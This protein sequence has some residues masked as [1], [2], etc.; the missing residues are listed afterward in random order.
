VCSLL[1][2][3]N[4][5]VD[6]GGSRTDSGSGAGAF[7]TSSSATTDDL[8]REL[9]NLQK[10][11]SGGKQI[12]DRENLL[13]RKTCGYDTFLSPHFLAV[14]TELSAIVSPNVYT[15]RLWLASL[16]TL[17]LEM[18]ARSNKLTE[19]RA[20]GEY[21]NI[22]NTISNHLS[23]I[24]RISVLAAPE[25][26]RNLIPLAGQVGLELRNILVRSGT[27]QSN[28]ATVSAAYTRLGGF[29]MGIGLALKGVT[30]IDEQ[31]KV[32]LMANSIVA[33]AYFEDFILPQVK[34]TELYQDNQSIRTAI[35]EYETSSQGLASQSFESVQMDLIMDKLTIDGSAFLIALA[36][37]PFLA[38]KGAAI[39]S[40][41]GIPGAVGGAVLFVAAGIVIGV[42]AD[43]LKEGAEFI[44]YNDISA[45]LFTLA[46]V[47]DSFVL[48]KDILLRSF[49]LSLAIDLLKT[50]VLGKGII[51][52]LAYIV[53][54]KNEEKRWSEFIAKSYDPVSDGV[55]LS[56]GIAI[57][58]LAQL[59]NLSVNCSETSLSALNYYIFLIDASGSMN[60]N[61]KIGQVK[62]AVPQIINDLPQ[63]ENAYAMVAYSSRYGCRREQIPVLIP[64]TN[65]A[66]SVEAAIDALSASGGTPM[67]AGIEKA[68]QYASQVIPEDASGMIILLADGQQN[69]PHGVS[70]PPLD[71]IIVE[72]MNIRKIRLSTIAYGTSDQQAQRTLV[73]LANEGHGIYVQ[74]TDPSLVKGKFRELILSQTMPE[75]K[76]SSASVFAGV[77]LLLLLLALL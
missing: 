65:D 74:A 67:R 14:N 29:I 44:L 8:E 66:E 15:R 6:Q 22:I 72:R 16:W 4:N 61:N 53:P 58:S 21:S 64:F 70:I 50:R 10:F 68:Y 76:L 36:A 56:L 49:S 32:Q 45:R 37:A 40:P 69:C 39:G 12:I 27:F 7:D 35:V 48:D 52:K 55:H 18:T 19:L 42:T 38:A 24:E 63:G 34:T 60:D 9:C 25:Q 17:A 13:G 46:L 20:S 28:R 41:L 26:S 30:A 57:D 23:D 47:S 31:Q 51:Q 1:L 3:C 62:K 33:W 77:M 5:E 54:I 73:T 59:R 43:Q 71:S 11:C 2:S 75:K